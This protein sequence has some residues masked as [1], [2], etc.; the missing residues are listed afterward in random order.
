[1]KTIITWNE[2]NETIDIL[3]VT[4]NTL[5]KA[6]AEK[7]STLSIPNNIKVETE[8]GIVEYTIEQRGG[9]MFIK[10]INNTI[11]LPSGDYHECYLVCVNEEN[12]NYKYYKLKKSDTS[13]EV[14]ASYGR[15]G[16]KK[17]EL[18]GER[19]Y[20]YPSRMYWIK[21]MEKIAKGY[22]DKSNIYLNTPIKKSTKKDSA[23]D[24]SKPTTANVSEYLFAKLQSFARNKIE[25]SC[26][27]TYVTEKMIKESKKLLGKMYERK[28][29]K[30]FNTQLLKLLAISPRKVFKVSELLANTK[31]DFASIIDREENLILAMESL[32]ISKKPKKSFADFGIEVYIANERQKKVVL[33]HLD[34]SLKSKVKNI[35]R[36]INN[37]TQVNFDNYLKS[38]NITTVKQL[39]HGSRNE[40]WGS[41]IMNGLQLNPNAVITGKMFGNGIYFA[42]SSLKSWNYTSYRGSYWAKGNDDLGIMGLYATAYGTPLDVDSPR[43]YTQSYLNSVN[44]NCVHA[45]AGTYLRNDEIIYYTEDAMTLN[46][47]VEFE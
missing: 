42:N 23:T 33:S 40:N 12:N 11:N 43:G 36:I 29:V 26:V 10:E 39:W 28:T 13:D 5:Y 19:S 24:L 7:I 44:K 16:T 31:D 8:I 47:I 37:R 3:K 45:H 32:G 2:G 1:M 18:Y 35:Y 14:I 38:S 20:S 22:T 34:D 4:E 15:I 21:Y 9:T 17:G 41:I 6:I 25:T 30:G 27:N 46:Y